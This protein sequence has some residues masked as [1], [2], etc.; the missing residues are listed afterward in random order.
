MGRAGF[1]KRLKQTSP[2]T[3]KNSEKPLRLY[4]PCMDNAVSVKTGVAL[5]ELVT[6]TPSGGLIMRAISSGRAR[7]F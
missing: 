7:V 3:T 4:L 6:R 2:T 1:A 5:R